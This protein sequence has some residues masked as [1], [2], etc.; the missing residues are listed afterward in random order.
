MPSILI[1][2]AN[3]FVGQELATGLLNACPDTRLTL[4]DVTVAPPVP[5]SAKPE[6][7]SRITSIKADLTS[8][9][10]VDE[11]ISSPS[12]YDAVYILHGI[13][14]GASEANFDLGMKINFFSVH[15][16]FERLRKV[17]PGIKVI[18]ASSLAVYGPTPPGFKINERNIPPL[19]TSSYA[20]AKIATELLLND[21]SRRGF[22]DGRSV[23]LPTVTVRAG[24]PTG[25]A[26]SFASGIIREPLKGEK[27]VIPVKMDT[28]LW[29]CSPYV[30]VE[31]MIYA[32]DIPKE[33]FGDSR[34]V[35]L[36]GIKV[37]VTEMLEVLEQV[38]G[39][40][41]RALVEEKYDEA[42]DR[43]V[44]GWSPDFDITWAKELGFKEDISFLESVKRYAR[45]HVH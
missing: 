26:S 1:T 4:T 37:S 9:A 33:R 23:R 10:A 16:M 42:V 8:Q 28:E 11:L 15:Y 22:L 19:P 25:A 20:T 3:G 39:K 31:N 38:G 40:E 44:Q 30:V 14:S 34:A 35:N 6:D 2:G 45:D 29:I 7:A 41:K 21:Y 24:A 13:M 27:S 32:K 17:I 43:I 18:F 12:Q 36:P 5:P